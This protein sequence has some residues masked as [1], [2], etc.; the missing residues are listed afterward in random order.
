MSPRSFVRTA[1]L[2]AVL[3]TTASALAAGR[4]RSSGGNA[5][6]PAKGKTVLTAPEGALDL[7]ALAKVDVKHFAARGKRV[8]RSWLRFK[9]RRLAPTTAYS[10]WIDD[11]TT[12]DDATLVQVPADATLT[13][14]DGNDLL[15]FDTKHGGTLPFGASLADLGGKTVE[16]RDAEGLAVFL[17]GTLPAGR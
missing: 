2:A 5:G 6:R 3:V 10:L 7:D 13:N 15:R 9:V 11:P 17:T 16:V 4:G 14:E 8:E 1:A 12:P